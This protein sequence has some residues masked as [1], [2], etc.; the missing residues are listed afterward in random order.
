ML[1]LTLALLVSAAPATAAPSQA[2]APAPPAARPLLVTVDDLP[3]A[4]GRLHPD[5]AERRQITGG[6][7]AAL[8]RHKVPAVGL[9]TWSNVRDASDEALLEAWLTAGHELGSHSDRHLSLTT[10][11]ADVWLADVERGR[12]QLAAFLERRAAARC[13]SSAFRSCARGTQRPSST[14]PAP[15]SRRRGCAT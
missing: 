5:P 7:L 9:V 14:R 10:T 1:G 3:I 2:S 13:A 8:A 15:G 12:A 6:L 4:A 11:D